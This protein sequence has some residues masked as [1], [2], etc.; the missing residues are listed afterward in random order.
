MTCPSPSRRRR[1]SH[2]Y[3]DGLHAEKLALSF[4]T[5]Q[6][7]SAFAQRLKTPHGEIDLIVGN[8]DWLIAVE[9]KYRQRSADCAYALT[10]RQSQRLLAAFSYVLECYPHWQK[11]NTRFDVILTDHAQ[12]IRHIEDA[13]RLM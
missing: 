3:R 6:G 2:A 5:E 4:L 13:L 11:P 7:F 1:G 10:A 9:V 12:H 8:D